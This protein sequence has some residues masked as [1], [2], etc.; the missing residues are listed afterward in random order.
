MLV[1][2]NALARRE[3]S[4]PVPCGASL[5]FQALCVVESRLYARVRADGNILGHKGIIDS[6]DVDV[7]DS[8][9]LV[10][11]IVLD[12]LGYLRTARRCERAGNTE[13]NLVHE[14]IS[15]IRVVLKSG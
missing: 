3:D 14:S 7:L 6:D 13:L 9:R 8:F 12:I 15:V 2:M 1:R 11:V 10:L 5:S 4:A